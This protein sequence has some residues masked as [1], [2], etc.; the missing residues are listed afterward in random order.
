MEGDMA[1]ILSSRK[2][3]TLLDEV[4][5]NDASFIVLI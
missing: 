1:D 5:Q 3:P 4:I 2:N